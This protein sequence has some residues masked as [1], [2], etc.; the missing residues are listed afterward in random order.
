MSDIHSISYYLLQS[1][2]IKLEPAKPFTWASGWKS[3]IYC[4]NR[5]TLSFPEVRTIIRDALVA[6]IRQYYP[7]TE[8]IAGVATGAIAQ[9]A[10]VAEAMNLPFVYVRS[11]AKEHGLGNRI[12]GYLEAGKKT[13][14]VEDL[15][16]TGG[17]SLTAVDAIRNAGNPVL[18]MVAIFTYGFPLAEAN[19]QKADCQ[20]H[21]LT[22]YIEL[23]DL[24]LASGY[25]QADQLDLLKKWRE[26]PQEWG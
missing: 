2:A 16:S 26:A 6:T 10:L 7:Q 24:A 4:D 14:V 9:G 20:L 15:I 11:S 25:I 5:R 18:G 3:P 8:V 23:L 21:T 17:S 13:V 12:E 1:K 19:F 22:N